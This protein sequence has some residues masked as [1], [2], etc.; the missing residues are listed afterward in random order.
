MVGWLGLKPFSLIIDE[1]TD[2]STVKCL[3]IAVRQIDVKLGKTC[4]N[5]FR[6]VQPPS[7][8]GEA[9]FRS[10]M[11]VLREYE[12]PLKNFVGIVTDNASSMVGKRNG[13]VALL[14]KEVPNLFN[15]G[16]VCHSINLINSSSLNCIP[17]DVEQMLRNI[18]NY[19]KS[20]KRQMEFRELQDIFDV[21]EHKLLRLSDTRW[22][23]F[24]SVASRTL[25][26]WEVL[27]NYFDKAQSEQQGSKNFENI[28]IIK[29]GLSVINKIYLSF[30][31]YVLKIMNELNVN[32]QSEG[33]K[34]IY[35][36]SSTKEIL[37]KLFTN[38]F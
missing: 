10:V 36:I 9:I 1:T 2:I 22:L 5:Y 15:I 29:N 4:D 37:V 25:E 20:S 38:F 11:N 26:Q 34:I 30:L 33:S 32:F 6:L 28:T 18:F 8:T 21:P 12:V 23:S 17:N 14:K 19:F 31:E 7:G 24:E 16:C 3:V 13:V 27:Q 35:L